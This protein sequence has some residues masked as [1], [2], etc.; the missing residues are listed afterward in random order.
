MNKSETEI[1]EELLK[2]GWRV[3]KNGAPDFF[4]IRYVGGKREIVAVEVKTGN[5]QPSP[6]QNEVHELLKQAGIPVH[7]V[8]PG[9]SLHELNAKVI[10]SPG[11]IRPDPK[12][13]R[14]VTVTRHEEN[15]DK[16]HP[17]RSSKALERRN[18]TR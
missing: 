7:I 15:L 10:F 5:Q 11:L 2:K 16:G 8:Y 3:L 9:D 6:I 1:K 12:I 4:C 13:P 17:T 18:K 14:N